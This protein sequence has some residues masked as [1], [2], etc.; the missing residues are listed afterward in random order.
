MTSIVP[1][2]GGIYQWRQRS[3]G[4]KYY[5]STIDFRRR[6]KDHYNLLCDNKH[7]NIHL[8][9]AW[10]K[11]GANDF[12]FEVVEIVT[13]KAKMLIREQWYLDHAVKWGKDF[14]IAKSAGSP[15]I[16]WTKERRQAQ[17]RVM[18]GKILPASTRE[19]MGK[20]HKANGQKP[21]SPKGKTLPE[22][23]KKKIGDAN[24]GKVRS[25]ELRAKISAKERNR[26]PEER[27]ELTKRQNEGRRR[28]LEAKRAAGISNKRTFSEEHKRKISE[29]RK[30]ENRGRDEKGQF[31]KKRT[32]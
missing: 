24:R 25:K 17:A 27:A 14:N 10:N 28:T 19:R 5:G 15:A 11:Y 4:R 3:T 2:A 13:D 18:T 29:A 7:F 22:A 21:P 16:P 12:V 20:A 6:S 23:Q 8:Q 31:L 32:K 26:T 1:R 30:R 9:R